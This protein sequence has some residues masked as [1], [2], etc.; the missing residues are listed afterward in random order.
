MKKITIVT[1]FI[2]IGRDNWEGVVNGEQIPHFIKRGVGEYFKSFERLAGLKNDIIIF[3]EEKYFD[4]IKSIREDIVCINISKI[5][6]VNIDYLM[7]IR[8]VQRNISYI[9]FV[10]SPALPEYWSAEYVYVNFL[11]SFFC[12]YV[13]KNN[14]NSNHDIAWIDFGYVRENTYCPQGKFWE[15]DT[16]DKINL[17]VL[18]DLSDNWPIFDIIRNNT[19]Y[20]QGCHIIAPGNLWTV[21]VDYMKDSIN[22]L[23][24][25]GLV[26]DDQTLLLM[27]YRKYPE[28]FN[29]NSGDHNDWFS[30]FKTIKK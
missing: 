9:N 18:G 24:K 1:A 6:D 12:D 10:N 16:K 23:F 13:Y 28:I 8:E 27:S 25:V 30:A 15:F 29:I 5:W 11:K 20:V 14:L 19:V 2:D 21:L 4:K 17:F 26:D 7:K 3:T 22:V